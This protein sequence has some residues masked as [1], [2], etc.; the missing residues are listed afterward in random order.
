MSCATNDEEDEEMDIDSI[1]Q[2]LGGMRP[3][4][5]GEFRPMSERELASIE[6]AIGAVLPAAYKSLLV[7]YG[8]FTFRGASDDNP[9]IFFRAKTQ[10]PAY[11]VDR[12]R[13]IFRLFYGATSN[14]GPGGLSS[15]IAF[16]KD[17]IPDTLIPIGGDGGAGQICLGIKGNETG[18]VYYWDQQN[19]PLDEEDYLADYGEPRPAAAMFQNIYLVANSFADF[20]QRLELAEES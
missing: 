18:K 1:S 7:K 14:P 11:V 16:F 6:D 9:F 17:R 20:L 10:L 3:A 15:K 19:E 5:G 4:G 8:A 12:G 13:S 2:R